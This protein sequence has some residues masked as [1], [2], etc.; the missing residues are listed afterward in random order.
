MTIVP[1]MARHGI[2][3][4]KK[5]QCPRRANGYSMLFAAAAT[6]VRLFGKPRESVTNKH[7]PRER[8][9]WVQRPSCEEQEG[10]SRRGRAQQRA[11]AGGNLVSGPFDYGAKLLGGSRCWCCSGMGKW[12]TIR[13]VTLIITLGLAGPVWARIPKLVSRRA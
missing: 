11:R 13:G 8:T 4:P 3:Q 7:S 2:C 1:I 6:A 12:I 9:L 5:D 10:E